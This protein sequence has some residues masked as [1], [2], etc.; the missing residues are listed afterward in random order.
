M[1]TSDN[2]LLVEIPIIPC[3]KP[4]M[5]VGDRWKSRPIVEKYW[6]FKDELRLL[7]PDLV[8]PGSYQ[9]EFTFPMPQSWSQKKKVAYDG[10]PHQSR[11]DLD[12]LLK[13]LNDCLMDEDSYIWDV[14]ATKIWGQEGCI[15]IWQ[16]AA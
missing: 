10:Q 9:V 8:L 15:R 2:S 7:C 5:T 13:A 11:P 14:R 12:N 3:A 16:Q 1:Q 6:R 4:R